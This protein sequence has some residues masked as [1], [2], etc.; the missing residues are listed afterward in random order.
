MDEYLKPEPKNLYGP[1]SWF[2][3][4]RTDIEITGHHNG[5]AF[6][7]MNEQYDGSWVTD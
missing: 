5:F 4:A 6:E 7:K 3:R 2:S 1:S